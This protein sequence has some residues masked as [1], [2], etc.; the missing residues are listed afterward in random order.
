MPQQLYPQ[1]NIPQ[2]PWDKRL[3]GPQSQSGC[4][5]KE[6]NLAPTRIS[7]KNYLTKNICILYVR[8]EAFIM[9]KCTIIFS[10]DHQCV[11]VGFKTN[12]LKISC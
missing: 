6:K 10:E 1:G 3:S 5:G 4:Y 8:L 9:N 11:K 2:Y 12:I 7:T